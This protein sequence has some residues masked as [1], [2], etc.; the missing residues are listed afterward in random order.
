MI[1]GLDTAGGICGDGPIE[2]VSGCKDGF[3]KVWDIW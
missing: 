1:N 3:I 2:I